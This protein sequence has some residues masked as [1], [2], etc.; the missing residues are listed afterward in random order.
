AG[1][2]RRTTQVAAEGVGRAGAVP[3]DVGEVLRDL[4]VRDRGV[5]GVVDHDDA[6]VDRH[7]SDRLVV[8]HQVVVDVDAVH[9]VHGDADAAG[10]RRTALADGVVGGSQVAGRLPVGG[11]R[12]GV[13]EEDADAVAA[14][15]VVGDAARRA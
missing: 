1:G 8:L 3:V 11:V 4:V 10:R 14:H 9:A 5:A 13:E 7:R 2:H 15:R 12:T 6:T